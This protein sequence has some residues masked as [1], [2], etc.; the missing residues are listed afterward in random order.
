MLWIE[1]GCFV[2]DT[3]FI[4]IIVTEWVIDQNRISY[5]LLYFYNKLMIE[6]DWS[7]KPN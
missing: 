4:K 6:I 2:K 5:S 7:D 1:K 3:F